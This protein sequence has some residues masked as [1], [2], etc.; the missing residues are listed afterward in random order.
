MRLSVD[1]RDLLVASW[2][3]DEASVAR[4]LTDGLEPAAV[5]GEHLVS[6]IF[7][8]NTGG[9]L[10]RLPLP[11]FSQLNLRVYTTWRGELA[12]YFLDARVS[13]AGMAGG[14]FAPVRTSRIR[15]AAGSA[16][17]PGLGLRV[18]YLVDEPTDP[19]ALGNLELGLVAGGELRALRVERGPAEW[20]AAVPTETP[21][22]DP[23]LALGF[24]VGE[25][26]SLLYVDSTRFEC[27]LPPRPLEPSARPS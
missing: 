27:E 14:L 7:F 19:G 3:T 26:H 20:R 16:E 12:A 18:R 2:R 25:P 17:A 5:G 11:G 6:A 24:D 9:R 15:V 13:A 22:V 1:V 21:R 8:R 23:L 10:G 4:A